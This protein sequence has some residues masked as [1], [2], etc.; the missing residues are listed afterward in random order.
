MAIRAR[1]VDNKKDQN[2][3]WTNR[4]GTVYDV[5]IKTKTADGWKTHGKRGFLTRQEAAQYEAEMKTKLL[6]PTFVP[7]KAVDEKRTLKEYLESWL[8][9]H[10]NA[11]LRPSTVYSYQGIIKNHIIPYIGNLTL[12]KVTPETLDKLFAVLA[13]KGLSQ[14]TVRYTQR[15]LSV[16]LEAA[17]KYNYIKTNPAK[18]IITKFKPKPEVPDPYTV[19]QVQQ[20]FSNA[21]GKEWQMHIVLAGLYGLRRGEVLGLRWRNV[22]LEN[23]KFSIVEQLPFKFST[24]EPYLKEFAPTKSHTR[25]LP[26]TD[27]TLPYFIEQRNLYEKHKKLAELSGTP[28]YDNELL[29]SRPDGRVVVPPNMSSNFG[30]FLR[31]TGMP[32]I[33]FHDLRHTA[34]TNMHQLTGDFYTVSQILGHTL[35]GIGLQLGISGNLDSV[36]AQYVDVR[37]ERKKEVLTVYHEAVLPE[38]IRALNERYD[39]ERSD[40]DER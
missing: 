33:R 19:E 37:L 32:H 9:T 10:G 22:D 6:S 13:E 34:A 11:N 40:R 15:V 23:Q 3:N 25:E 31:S 12:S 5:N 30:S 28:F 29:I 21:I 4:P 16:S 27:A 26:I 2:G 20:L 24:K 35:K 39:R 18:D 1:Q 17:R 14:T 8:E 38:A 7:V 36:T